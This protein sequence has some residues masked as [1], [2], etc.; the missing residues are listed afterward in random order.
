M[1]T[2]RTQKGRWPSTKYGLAEFAE[3]SKHGLL[4]YLSKNYPV[5]M[6]DIPAT[7]RLAA[8]LDPDTVR[9]F[10]PGSLGDFMDLELLV[11]G[12]VSTHPDIPTEILLVTHSVESDYRDWVSIAARFRR[13]TLF[14]NLSKWYL[15]Y[16]MFHKG[17]VTDRDVGRN[18]KEVDNLLTRFKDNLIVEEIDGISDRG[19]AVAL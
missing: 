8:I 13:E 17:F 4:K 16:K 11:A 15:F 6:D 12:A 5:D 1:S 7:D 19:P 18:I 3:F 2:R 10:T 14:S 9:L